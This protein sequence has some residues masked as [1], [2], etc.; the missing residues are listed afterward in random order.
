MLCKHNW[1]P[2]RVL[3]QAKTME[4]KQQQ[5]L[6]QQ[7]RQQRSEQDRLSAAPLNGLISCCPGTRTRSDACSHTQVK[8]LEDALLQQRRERVSRSG[9]SGQPELLGSLHALSHSIRF[10]FAPAGQGAGG[11]ADAAAQRARQ[12]VSCSGCSGRPGALQRG[13]ITQAFGY[14]LAARQPKAKGIP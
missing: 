7:Q 14:W 10:V 1:S 13:L 2:C 6:L 11:R 3:V 8:A 4:D 12:A 5:Q 9:C